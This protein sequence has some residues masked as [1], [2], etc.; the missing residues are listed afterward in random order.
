VL[1]ICK[2]AGWLVQP[3][4]TGDRTIV[5]LVQDDLRVRHHKPG[6]VYVG[7]VHR[8][9]RPVSGVLVVARTSKAAARLAE[10]FRTGRVEKV[11]WALVEKPPRPPSG[12]LEH[13][14]IKDPS[15]NRVRVARRDEAQARLAQLE[16]RT[17]GVHAGGT[18]LEVRLHT[19]RS[20]QIRVQLAA[21]GSIVTGDLRYGSRT[22][23]GERIALHA[24]RLAFQHPTR[25]ET[26]TVQ[27][28]P[29]PE[30]E[31]LLALP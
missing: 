23:L 3:D 12:L 26:I 5:D 8:L 4:R 21:A 20:H 27:A 31:P 29:P 25:G 10:Q 22:P 13:H 14:L 9:D 16:Y 28:E 6:N 18:L 30:W 11:Y 24:R 19:G 1:A 15:T 2:P 17:L 7:V